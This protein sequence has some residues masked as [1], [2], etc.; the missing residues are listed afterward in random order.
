MESAI[1]K[2]IQYNG[3]LYVSSPSTFDDNERFAFESDSDISS[4]TSST[5]S[6]AQFN[7][8]PELQRQPER[9]R[10][11]FSDQHGRGTTSPP[12]RSSLRSLMVCAVL[13]WVLFF[14]CA[15]AVVVFGVLYPRIPPVLLGNNVQDC[16]VIER[17][18]A[19]A[20]SLQV[21]KGCS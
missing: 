6:C 3:R 9:S 10:F 21:T 7:A 4:V 11:L 8:Q 17:M 1:Q 15:G 14:C 12:P 19:T 5:I 13:M 18:N 20:G 16:G 2:S